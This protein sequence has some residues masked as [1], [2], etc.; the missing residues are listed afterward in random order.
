MNI[1]IEQNN[2]RDIDQIMDIAKEIYKPDKREIEKYHNKEEWIERI[3][4]GLLISAIVDE[5]VVGFVICYPKADAFH[6][7]NAGVLEGYRQLGLWRKLY[8][9]VVE[10][11]KNKQYKRITINTYKKTFPN[12]YEFL[13]KEHFNEA[14]VE[15][16]K[17]YFEKYLS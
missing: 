7:W 6:I 12:M 1:R 5:D 10:F 17:S 13:V 3:K 14:K 9:D 15:N 8:N 4:N 16:G 11:A 2:I